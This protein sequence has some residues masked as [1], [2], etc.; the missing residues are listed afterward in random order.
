[1]PVILYAVTIAAGGIIGWVLRGAKEEK[2]N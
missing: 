1:M 2:K